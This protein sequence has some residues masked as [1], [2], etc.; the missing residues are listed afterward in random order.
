MKRQS[1]DGQSFLEYT[2]VIGSIDGHGADDEAV[3]SSDG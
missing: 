1:V 2:M 3:Y